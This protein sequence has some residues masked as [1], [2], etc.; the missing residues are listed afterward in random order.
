MKKLLIFFLLLSYPAFADW[1]TLSPGLEYEPRLEAAAH[2]FRVDLKELDAD[3][4]TAA[5][6]GRAALSAAEYRDRAGA[7]LVVNGGFFETGFRGLGL[8]FRKGKTL[9]PLRASA[10]GILA[11]SGGA[12]K[13]LHRKEWSE[14]GIEA[15]LQVG[16]RLVVDGEIQKFK[17]SG[18]AR[19]SGVGITSDGKLEIALSEK[20][21]L[22]SEWAALL[23]KD[24]PNA[25]NLDGGGSTQISARSGEFVL[26]VE[27]YT[28][29]PNALAVFAK[30]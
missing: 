14:K 5:G 24:C 18:P 7:V 9:Q 4:L 27:G 13:I 19:R 22:L 10:W 21:M 29:V 15:A 3:V 26:N 1:R 12:A 2:F 20:P 6:F 8:L 16:P 11:L 25:L 28:A 23:A 30:P 17:E